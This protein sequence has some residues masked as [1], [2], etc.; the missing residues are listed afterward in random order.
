MVIAST[1][2]AQT[3]TVAYEGRIIVV[4]ANAFFYLEDKESKGKRS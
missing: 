2:G 4:V 3:T 1:Y